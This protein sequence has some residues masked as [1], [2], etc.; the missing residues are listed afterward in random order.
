MNKI[1]A[2]ILVVGGGAGGIAAA[3]Q[4][5]RCGVTTILAT[6]FSWLGGMLTSGGVAAP[7]GNELASWHTGLWGAYLK[8]LQRRQAGGLD[9]SWVSLFAYHPACGATIFA[10]WVAQIPNLTWIKNCKPLSVTKQNDCITGVRFNRLFIEA[11]IIVD[12]TELGDLLV[13]TDIPYR[14]GWESFEQFH[15]PSLRKEQEGIQDFNLSDLSEQ[16]PVQAPTWV[17]LLQDNSVREVLAANSS[18]DCSPIKSQFKGAW[19]NYGTEKFINYGKLTNDL[20]MINWPIAG[21]DYGV[22]LNRLIGSPKVTQEYLV[23]AYNHSYDF[24]SYI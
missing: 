6:E 19:D 17:F 10:D 8:E 15:E 18:S 23:E 14:W 5:S 1:T 9:N 12:A 11:K 7:D 13:L 24:A 20:F 2:D 22:N 21:N 16:Y 3:I 4:A